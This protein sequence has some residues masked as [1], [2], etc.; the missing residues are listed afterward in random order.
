MTTP[1]KYLVTAALPYANGPL[2]LGHLAGV[3]V[4]SDIYVRYLRQ[5]GHEVVFVCG[6]DEHG[7]A[8]TIKAKKEGI[9]PQAVVDKYHKILKDVFD[10]LDIDFDIYHR[11]S[12]ELHHETAKDFFRTLHEKG[13][14]EEKTTE[15]YYDEEFDQ[16]LADRYIKGTCPKCDYDAA[17][18]DQCENCG[19]TLS[20]TELINPIST[21]SEKKPVKRETTHWFLPL[22]Q[23]EDWLREWINQGVKDGVQLHDPKS[24]KKHVLGQCNSWLDSGLHP[25]A[26][27]RDLNWGVDVPKEIPGSEGKK[28]YVWLDAPIGYISATKQ[29]AKDNGKDWKSYWQDPDCELIHFLGKD[30][31]V[32]H[33]IIFPSI[34]AVHGDYNLPVNVPANQFLNLEG[35]KLSTSRNWAV[36]G[37]EYLKELPNRV[38]ELRYNLA[39]NMPEQRDSEFTWSNFQE[40]T[41]GE[42]VGKFANLIQRVMVLTNK[43]FDGVVPE[44][45]EQPIL[46][47]SDQSMQTSVSKEIEQYESAYLEYGKH[48]MQYNFRGALKVMMDLTDYGNQFLQFNEPWKK[49]KTDEQSV[50][51]VLY[52]G[53][54]LMTVLQKM[55]S[56]FMPKTGQKILELLKAE[57]ATNI[58]AGHQIN[59]PF[60]LFE[61]IE[62]DVINAQRDKLIKS[63]KMETKDEIVFDDFQK[64]D[65]R[66]GTITAA[67]KVEGADKLLELSV[68]LGKEQR[69]IVSGIAEYYEA[70]KV[71][72]QR[73]VVV[74]NLAPRKLRGIMSEGMI[75]MVED[76]EGKLG[77]VGP[78]D[79]FGNGLS[80]A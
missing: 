70:D 3:Y 21:L 38:D 34:L 4:P 5:E 78:E 24:W 40:T 15:Q 29:W 20:P 69:T 57:D 28:M 6:S 44:P 14:F 60:H 8:I 25:R 46:S 77:F 27:T 41:N 80:I 35:D 64:I 32:F 68:D 37:H 63:E 76:E 23:Y 7:A 75:L 53:I 39:R 10:E 22:N 31:I 13:V 79:S 71:I 33:C 43:Y 58:E 2:H 12:S 65:L 55:S 51:N 45:D 56:P 74:V 19:S 18:G 59:A 17:Y 48:M 66:S 11:T 54:K 47:G 50:K 67:K 61:R 62:D 1:K 72:G 9:E 52:C 73:V 36:W 49:I 30:N 26:I 42:L 16:F